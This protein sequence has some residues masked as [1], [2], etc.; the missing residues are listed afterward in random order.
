MR[1]SKHP[2]A[3]CDYVYTLNKD[4]KGEVPNFRSNAYTVVR[5]EIIQHWYMFVCVQ[6]KCVIQWIK[7]CSWQLVLSSDSCISQI[8]CNPI[9]YSDKLWNSFRSGWSLLKKHNYKGLILRARNNTPQCSK[10]VRVQV[11]LWP[12][13]I[14]D[15]LALICYILYSCGSSVWMNVQLLMGLSHKPQCSYSPRHPSHWLAFDLL[16]TWY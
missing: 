10:T 11:C 16:L 9:C 8:F 12:L 15:C 6:C 2:V 13:S 7:M 3:E 1:K 5:E 14:T 4:F